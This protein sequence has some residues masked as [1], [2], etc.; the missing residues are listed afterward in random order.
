M[1]DRR[2]RLGRRR[3]LKLAAPDRY[4]D[5]RADRDARGDAD[6]RRTP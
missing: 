4:P 3:L 2:R 5:E 1:T 6:G